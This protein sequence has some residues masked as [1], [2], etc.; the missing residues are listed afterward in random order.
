MSTHTGTT[1]ASQVTVE[2]RVIRKDGRV[3]DLGVIAYWHRN[4]L[5]RIWW[6]VTQFL[7]GRRAGQIH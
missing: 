6:R 7:R 3:E 4:P 5:R 2:A 1:G